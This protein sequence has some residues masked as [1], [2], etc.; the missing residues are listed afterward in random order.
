MEQCRADLKFPQDHSSHQGDSDQ[1]DEV[2]QACLMQIHRNIGK[3]WGGRGS[4]ERERRE[5]RER[6][7]GEKKRPFEFL[8]MVYIFSLYTLNSPSLSP[9]I[10]NSHSPP[11]HWNLTSRSAMT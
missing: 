11:L 4:K 7:G 6:G 8:T 3:G 1:E 2:M 9:P 10:K 5:G